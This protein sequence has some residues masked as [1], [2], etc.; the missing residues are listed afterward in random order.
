MDEI[1]KGSGFYWVTAQGTL[2]A[3]NTITRPANANRVHLHISARGTS[4][5][6]PTLP[7]RIRILMSTIASSP[8]LGILMET[9]PNLTFS[10]SFWGNVLGEAFTLQ[11]LND[12]VDYTVWEMFAYDS[13]KV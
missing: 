4:A 13:P 7:W 1:I 11:A 9:Q 8:R 6:D 12:T 2:T 10:R 5:I 3:N